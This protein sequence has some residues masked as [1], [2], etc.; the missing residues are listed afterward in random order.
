MRATLIF[1]DL[2]IQ[3]A[4]TRNQAQYWL[5]EMIT[6]I[7]DLIDEEICEKTLHSKINLYE[8]DLI[9]NDYGF[10]EWLEDT[11]ILNRELYEFAL[12]LSIQSPAYACLKSQQDINDEYFRSEFNLKCTDTKCEALGI[13]L[14]SDGI[15]IS[16]PSCEEWLVDSVYIEQFLYDETDENLDFPTRSLHQVRHASQAN[17]VDNVILHWRHELLNQINN[18][19]KLLNYWIS[20][21]PNLDQSKENSLHELQSETLASA[22]NRLWQLNN[23]CFEWKLKNEN[24]P[25]YPMK[26]RPESTATMQQKNLADMRLSTCPRQ[27]QKH[28][29]MHCNI[30][31]KGFRLYWLENQQQKRITIGYI[32]P[33]LPTA[34]IKAK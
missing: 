10:Q 17:H 6:T 7:A 9:E 14:L 23:T 11:R 24:E 20:V 27:G 4:P 12:Q 28:F 19:Q 30:Q 1:N 26:A 18:S 15:A 22:V 21:F 33:H 31:P 25:A 34:K 13:A 8:I 29:V 3:A 2:S 5:S 16:L 32:G